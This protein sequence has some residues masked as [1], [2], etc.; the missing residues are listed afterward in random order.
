MFNSDRQE[1]VMVKKLKKAA[2]KGS[3]ELLAKQVMDSAQK[4][5]LA[6]LGAFARAQDEGGKVFNTLVEQGKEIEK[7]TR[8]IAGKAVENAKAQ[9]SETMGKAAGKWD[10]L[11]QVFE[12]RVHRSL[13]RLGVVS[14]NDVEDLTRQVSE[15]SESV[16]T[17]IAQAKRSGV[18]KAAPKVG[19]V[20]RTAAKG[21]ATG[22]ARTGVKTAPRTVKK[23]KSRL[24]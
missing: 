17:L 1:I 8:Q 19:V 12:D 6:G 15:L 21:K 4:I 3:G 7:K 11:E 23:V 13:N 18:S 20:K 10:K 2:S 14:S 16:R 5:W 24:K 22:A 9:A